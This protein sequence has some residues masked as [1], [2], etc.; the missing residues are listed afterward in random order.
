MCL[1]LSNYY[2]L[3]ITK[4]YGQTTI[5]L[6]FIPFCIKILLYAVFVIF[7]YKQNENKITQRKKK[8][9]CFVKII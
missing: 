5:K 1:N 3:L 8:L 4:V 2:K 7:Y 9:T 6:L